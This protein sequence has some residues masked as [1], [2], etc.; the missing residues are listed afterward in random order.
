MIAPDHREHDQR[1]YGRAFDALVGEQ[2]VL[3]GLCSNCAI[4][5]ANSDDDAKFLADKAL[6]A[7]HTFLGSRKPLSDGWPSVSRGFCVVIALMTG[8]RIT[9]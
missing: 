6:I 5:M 4:R 1:E 8:R 2:A 9:S 3:E 7:R